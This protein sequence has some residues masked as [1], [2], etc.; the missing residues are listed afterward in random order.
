MLW[1]TPSWGLG[2]PRRRLDPEGRGTW[3]LR[4]VVNYQPPSSGSRSLRR[5]SVPENRGTFILKRRY[6]SSGSS[7]ILGLWILTNTILRNVDKY[8]KIDIVIWRKVVRLSS[9]RTGR[10]YSQERFLVLIAVRDWVD[11][12]AIMRPEGLSDWKIP[13]TSSGIEPVIFRLVA[14]CLNQLRH[15]VPPI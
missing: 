14:Q 2:G 6:L 13:V 7:G 8:L 4:N 12:K 5:L 1:L 9:L 10:L 3:L 15:R 11:P